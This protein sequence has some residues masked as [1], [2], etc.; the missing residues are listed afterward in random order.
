[1]K[2]KVCGCEENFHSED[3]AALLPCVECRDCSGFEPIKKRYFVDVYCDD[4]AV[5][6]DSFEWLHSQMKS[7]AK[8]FLTQKRWSFAKHSQKIVVLD[9]ETETEIFTHER[10]TLESAFAVD[11]IHPPVK[12]VAVFS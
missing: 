8:R 9:F 7:N 2:C 12:N 11:T 5:W 1:M 3:W 10:Q 6:R 4:V